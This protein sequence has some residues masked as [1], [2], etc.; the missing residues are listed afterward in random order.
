VRLAYFILGVL[1]PLSA[2]MLPLIRPISPTGQIALFFVT[3][4]LA[5]LIPAVESIR[6]QSHF[7]IT[8]PFALLAIFAGV[9]TIIYFV[10]PATLASA[11]EGMIQIDILEFRKIYWLQ[12]I[13]YALGIHAFVD[14]VVTIG[15][16]IGVRRRRFIIRKAAA[17]EN[18]ALRLSEVREKAGKPSGYSEF[19]YK[20][21][22]GKAI[23]FV[24]ERFDII[25]YAI[26]AFTLSQNNAVYFFDFLDAEEDQSHWPRT[27]TAEQF[28]HSLW[29]TPVFQ[30]KKLY[31]IQR[32]GETD[33]TALMNSDE[34]QPLEKSQ[35]QDIVEQ[36]NA[37]YPLLETSIP[38]AK[39][40]P[41][42]L[43]RNARVL[44]LFPS[45][46]IRDHGQ[47]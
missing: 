36:L 3:S 2:F 28:L 27:I 45:P 25:H 35:A 33:F 18:M 40:I 41:N 17:H 21:L 1:L 46:A 43:E 29:Q 39:E 8:D 23:V 6:K 14:L 31:Y 12:A 20:K 13:P 26:S 5:G 22:M 37:R 42:A 4:V 11:M 7:R 19:F 32:N 15:L 30:G 16:G 47:I 34:I 38:S 44:E 24:G 10:E 9:I